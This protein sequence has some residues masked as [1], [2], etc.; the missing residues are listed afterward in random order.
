MKCKSKDEADLILF[1]F[2]IID[3]IKQFPDP[4]K[5]IPELIMFSHEFKVPTLDNSKLSWAKR[6][7]VCC[8]DIVFKNRK[9]AWFLIY[10]IARTFA[11]PNDSSLLPLKD[12]ITR[13]DLET[14]KLIR[15]EVSADVFLSAWDNWQK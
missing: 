8:H 4:T 7:A 10:Y 2:E 11:Q 6:A 14:A 15:K 9:D 3:H 1:I 5:P 13:I 12:E